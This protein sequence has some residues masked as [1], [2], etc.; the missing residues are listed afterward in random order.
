MKSSTSGPKIKYKYMFQVHVNNLECTIPYASTV[1]LKLVRGSKSIESK[2]KIEV[3]GG[4]NRKFSFDEKLSILTTL[5]FNPKLGCCEE[6]KLVIR[7]V[8]TK[9]D[10]KAKRI[11]DWVLNT[12]EFVKIPQILAGAVDYSKFKNNKDW[13]EKLTTCIDRFGLCNFTVKT[14]LVEIDGDDTFSMYHGGDCDETVT[15]ASCMEHIRPMTDRSYYSKPIKSDLKPLIHVDFSASKPDSRDSI[16]SY[17][18]GED[19]VDKF[20][21]PIEKAVPLE[22]DDDSPVKGKNDCG[23]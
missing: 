19:K 5:E 16:T 11:G 14:E 18:V 2:K 8:T 9:G 17:I 23:K 6:K 20:G 10:G 13:V 4:S 15:D 7:F 22:L 3:D 21:N 1:S 12:A